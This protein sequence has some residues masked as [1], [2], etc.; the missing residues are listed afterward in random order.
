VT[1]R[2]ATRLGGPTPASFAWCRKTSSG[3]WCG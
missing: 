1:L 3:F 2:R